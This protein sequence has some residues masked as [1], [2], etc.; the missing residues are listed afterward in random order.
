MTQAITEAQ[1]AALEQ[2]YTCIVLRTFQ[3]PEFE[4]VPGEI[5][6]AGSWPHKS[7]LEE[8]RYIRRY[9]GKLPPK[10]QAKATKGRRFL[11]KEVKAEDE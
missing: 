1:K 5:I 8:H 11:V 10:S 3:G 7:K 4:F 2:D 6:D 9:T